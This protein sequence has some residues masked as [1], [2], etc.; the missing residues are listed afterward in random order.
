M[1]NTEWLSSKVYTENISQFKDQ[2]TNTFEMEQIAVYS[3][4]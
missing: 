3:C 2:N 4:T 1:I